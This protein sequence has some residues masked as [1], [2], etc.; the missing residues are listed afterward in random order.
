MK[1]DFTGRHLH[2]LVNR[3]NYLINSWV[4]MVFYF[5]VQLI[6]RFTS[7]LVNRFFKFTTNPTFDLNTFLNNQLI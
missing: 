1:L 2:D 3:S 6:L 5:F 4:E 7:D